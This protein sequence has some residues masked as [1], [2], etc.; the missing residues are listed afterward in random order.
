MKIRTMGSTTLDRATL[1]R[2]AEPDN[3]HYLQNQPLVAGRDVGLNQDPPPDLV[4]EV[5]IAH[6]DIDKL[7][8]YLEFQPEGEE[9]LGNW[10]GNFIFFG[11]A[12][13]EATLPSMTVRDVEEILRAVSP[14]GD[15]ARAEGC[16]GD[17]AGAGCL[18]GVSA[19]RI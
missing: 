12:Y 14:K 7:Q 10:A 5:D 11:Y 13:L 2:S 19:A 17:R 6:T 8:L 1:A 4:V 9:Y 15:A 16:G 3:A 18:L